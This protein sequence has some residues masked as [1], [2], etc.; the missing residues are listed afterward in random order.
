MTQF[1]M[2]VLM[3]GVYFY[4]ILIFFIL[5]WYMIWYI[6][7]TAIRSTPGCSSTAHIYTQTIHRT[8][9]KMKIHKQQQQKWIEFKFYFI[10]I[11]DFNILFKGVYVIAFVGENRKSSNIQDNLAVLNYTWC[12][13]RIIL[14]MLIT[15]LSKWLM[16]TFQ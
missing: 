3:E 16:F 10:L 4:F 1:S 13:E 9:I 6:L 2:A 5:M 15:W 14:F 8:Q 12:L 7:L 11:Y